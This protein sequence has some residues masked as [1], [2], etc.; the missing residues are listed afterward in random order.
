MK[1]G[2]ICNSISVTFDKTKSKV[3]LINTSDI[4]DGKVTNHTLVDNTG[5]K[6]SLKKP[7]KKTIFCIQKYALKIKDLLLLTLMQVIM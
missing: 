4:L 7:F 5:L 3:V 6:A 2:D 1:L